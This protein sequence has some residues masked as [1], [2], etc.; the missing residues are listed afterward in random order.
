MGNAVARRRDPGGLSKLPHSMAEEGVVDRQQNDSADDG[1]TCAVNG[2]DVKTGHADTPEE[3][4][5]PATDDCPDDAEQTV[6]DSSL[7]RGTRMILLA[8][9]PIPSPSRIKRSWTCDVPLSQIDPR[10]SDKS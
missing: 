4:K 1:G 8:N 6:N 7:A 3:A 2:V 10:A 5:Q 9:R